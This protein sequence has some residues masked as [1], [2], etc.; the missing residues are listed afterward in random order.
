MLVKKTRYSVGFR[1]SLLN[2]LLQRQWKSEPR[3]HGL[4]AAG[5]VGGDAWKQ[6]NKSSLRILLPRQWRL[7][8]GID[9]QDNMAR[10][11]DNICIISHVPGAFA[12]NKLIVDG[13]LGPASPIR[14]IRIVVPGLTELSDKW[15]DN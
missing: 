4:K 14:R 1:R 9:D 12:Q 11:I 5:K 8:Y 15:R 10:L 2:S 3:W 6:D 13:E 7:A